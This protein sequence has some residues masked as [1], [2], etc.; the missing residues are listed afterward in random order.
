M[1]EDVVPTDDDNVDLVTKTKWTRSLLRLLAEKRPVHA[2]GW[3][4]LVS[5]FRPRNWAKKHQ[6]GEQTA[7][8]ARFP[9]RD[10]QRQTLTS[11]SLHHHAAHSYLIARIDVMLHDLWLRRH[12]RLV[13]DVVPQAT[14]HGQPHDLPP[15]TIP[16]SCRPHGNAD[17]TG[18]ARPDH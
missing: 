16:H 9:A 6:I 3:K 7:T 8:S 11:L 18:W 10:R 4:H 2:F 1:I 15:T 17:G 12:P 5:P 14:A 13:C